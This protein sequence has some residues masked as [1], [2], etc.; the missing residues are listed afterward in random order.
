M[1]WRTID[2]KQIY[3][4]PWINVREDSIVNPAGKKGIYGVVEIPPG[5]FTVALNEQNDILLVRQHRYPTNITSWELPGG[6][7]KKENTP[8]T[9]IAEELAEEAH[10][11]ARS[12]KNLGK[13]QTQPGVTNELDIF[14]LATGVA[15]VAG[16]SHLTKKE[17]GIDDVRFFSLKEVLLMIRKGQI[18]HG[19][20]ITGLMLYI[21]HVK[22]RQITT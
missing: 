17:E 6:G 2:T 18:N 1:Q 11:Q 10:M 21:T 8:E 3:T 16:A 20:T 12:F 14:F 15:P 22:M 7:L 9:Q 19:Q 13:T 4:N 5:I